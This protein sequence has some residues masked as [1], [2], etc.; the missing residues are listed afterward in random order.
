[1]RIVLK[2]I[3]GIMA[4]AVMMPGYALAAY[5]SNSDTGLGALDYIENRHREER[6]NRLSEEQVKLVQDAAAMEERLRYPLDP[7]QPLPVAF[8]GEDLT[9]DER[10]GE[11]VAV[12][13]VDIVQMDRRRFQGEKVTGN[14]KEH[15][16]YIPDQAH[17]LQLPPREQRVTLDGYRAV[18]NYAEKTGSLEDVKGKAGEYYITGKRFEFYPDRIVIY[19]GT[20]TKCGAKNPD[21]HVSAEKIEF[22]PGKI[23]KMYHAKLWAGKMV[24]ATR[25]YYESKLT[26]ERNNDYPRIGYNKDDGAYIE[27]DFKYPFTDHITGTIHAHLN[28]KHGIRSN[29]DILYANRNF[30]A[31]AIYGY[32]ND[33]NNVWIQKEPGLILNYGRHIGTLPVSYN[34]KYEIGHWRSQKT[35][36]THQYY[37]VGLWRDPIV[38]HRW[39]LFLHTSYTI[40]R[41]SANDS[42]VRGMNY[43]VTLA[44]DFDP[45][46]AGFAGY[47]YSKSN[48][49]NSLFDYGLDAYSKK[50][51]AGISYRMDR[52]NRFVAGIEYDAGDKKL[53]D[54]DYYWFHDLHCSQLIMRYR[55]KRSQYE[56][57]WQFT[58]W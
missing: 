29:A 22:W 16:I 50:V 34:L 26:G 45:K 27:Q 23:M 31:Q 20:E 5:T 35:A 2:M 7:A 24:V 18:Y 53:K 25:K 40:T 41:E 58:P 48:T 8:E 12:G 21:Y 30:S 47:H 42:E 33:H 44:R 56:I 57:Q 32:Y 1:M 28:S 4:A 52:L 11:F 49:T 19:D 51:D 15:A 55:A 39:N 6:A 46:W 13:H 14:L 10:T 37:E 36:S 17:V 9:Y 43:D 38:F 3:C 54:I